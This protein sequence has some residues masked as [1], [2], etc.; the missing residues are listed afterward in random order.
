MARFV[1]IIKNSYT[2]SK[3]I[4]SIPNNFDCLLFYGPEHS[5]K[6][7]HVLS[8]I[9]KL[10]P[11]SLNYEKK[12]MVLYNNDE[13]LFKI[14]DI[15]VEINFTFLGCISKSLWGCIYN[16]VLL[17][18]GNK[19]FIL[20]CKNFCSINNDLLDNFYTYMNKKNNN[21]RYIFLVHNISCISN[22]ILDCCLIIPLKK[23]PKS[24][25]DKKS[26][27]NN[28][29]EQMVNH[30]EQHKPVKD[31]RVILYD[32]LVYNIDVYSFLYELLES[33]NRK[34]KPCDKKITKLFNEFN[35]IL[36]L[37]NNNY[38]SIYHLENFIFSIIC[39]LD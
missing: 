31:I 6:Y 37:F 5:N 36:K 39:I 32:L 35:K 24:H 17:L 23:T 15:H 13:Y 28:Y 11:S 2:S 38:R 14:S 26:I 25:L 19:P 20:L 16:Q 30:I 3:L 8:F 10:S 34:K 33:V 18:A 9:S 29:V 1:D 27:S 21:I 4:Q 12:M 7:E 22:N